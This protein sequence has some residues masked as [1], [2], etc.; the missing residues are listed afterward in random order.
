[1]TKSPALPGLPETTVKVAP[2][3]SPGGPAIHF[4]DLARTP[5]A[6]VAPA[7]RRTDS[8]TIAT[9]RIQNPLCRPS[10]EPLTIS[11]GGNASRVVAPPSKQLELWE[12]ARKGSRSD[13]LT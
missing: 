12:A 5:V 1:M 2:A 11:C 3:G 6:P 13:H 8:V 10:R 7:A 9:R 4:M